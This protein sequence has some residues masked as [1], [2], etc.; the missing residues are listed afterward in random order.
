MSEACPY[1]ALLG[2]VEFIAPGTVAHEHT[3]R[4]QIELHC[5]CHYDD[6]SNDAPATDDDVTAEL[7]C[8]AEDCDSL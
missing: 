5:A 6:E 1:V 4:M 7:P 3:R 8:P 2:C